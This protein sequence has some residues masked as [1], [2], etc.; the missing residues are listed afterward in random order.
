MKRET[1]RN[2]LAALMSLRGLSQSQVATQIDKSTA[3][4]NQYLK[5][6]YRGDNE[7][8]DT[9]V[10]QLLERYATKNREVKLDYVETKSAQDINNMLAIA[11]AVGEMKVLIGE[12]GLGKT[13]AVK[14]Y[15]KNHSDVIL[16]EVEPTF[17]AK[18]L[19]SELCDT[20]GLPTARNTHDMMRAVGKRLKNSGR[21]VIV[22]EAELLPY[23]ALEILRR[24]HDFAK[25]GIVLAGMPRLRANLR[26]KRGEYKQL[27]SRINYCHDLHQSLPDDDIALMATAFMG[28]DVYNA[29]LISH[30]EGSARRLSNLVKGVRRYADGTGK[31]ITVEMIK[32][33]AK[34]MIN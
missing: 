18:V 12:A 10:K 21:L 33:Y 20:L 5:G 15:T 4:V 13:M 32:Q 34:Q 17:N 29:V 9:A 25:V 28:T 14:E 31:P 19:L 24:L 1:L 6:S 27:Y 16:I 2:E 3:V 11:H 23:K 22:D 7:S 8:V 30:A 26:G